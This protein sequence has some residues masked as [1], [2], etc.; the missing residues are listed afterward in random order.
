MPLH[1]KAPNRFVEV[2]RKKA[3]PRHA[4]G[5]KPVQR[6]TSRLDGGHYR[7][8]RRHPVT[9]S[10]RSACNIQCTEVEEEVDQSLGPRP[11]HPPDQHARE[12]TGGASERSR[13]KP[14]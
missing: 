6:V 12:L 13:T 9:L 10:I 3:L 7:L 8:S 1:K 14:R 11:R 4:P 5:G 2:R